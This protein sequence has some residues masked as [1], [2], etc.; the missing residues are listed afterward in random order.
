MLFNSYSL[1]FWLI[2]KRGRINTLADR[3]KPH[4]QLVNVLLK[5]VYHKVASC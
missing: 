3:T 5:A 1:G 2:A 4:G